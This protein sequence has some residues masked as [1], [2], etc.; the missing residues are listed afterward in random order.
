MTFLELVQTFGLS[1]ALLMLAIVTGKRRW[2]VW[3]EELTACER[4]LDAQRAEYEGRLE[5]QRRSHA[6]REAELA[7]STERWQKLFFEILG[8]ISSLADVIAKR[9]V[10]GSPP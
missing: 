5:A 1:V 9:G 3:I 2:W 10:G 6:E 7:A 4:R 8:P